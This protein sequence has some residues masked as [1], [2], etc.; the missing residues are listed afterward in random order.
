MPRVDER[1]F[2]VD[3]RFVEKFGGH[4]ALKGGIALR[5]L[6]SPR[7]TNDL[8]YVS[9]P[10]KSKKDTAPTLEMQLS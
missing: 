2:H 7:K 6:D 9:V 4:A 3:I 5:L 1:L 8:D 10:Y